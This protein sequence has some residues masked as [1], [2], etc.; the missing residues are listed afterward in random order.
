MAPDMRASSIAI[1]DSHYGFTL[2][3]TVN[4]GSNSY[5]WTLTGTGTLSADFSLKEYNIADWTT[6]VKGK[7]VNNITAYSV[8]EAGSA[9]QEK[10]TLQTDLGSNYTSTDLY[11]DI[12]VGTSKVPAPGSW[13]N[14]V[15]TGSTHPPFDGHGIL[16]LIT[17]SKTDDGDYLWV[18]ESGGQVVSELFNKK[19]AYL[20]G[21][22]YGSFTL[23]NSPHGLAVTPEPSSLVLLGSGLLILALMLSWKRRRNLNKKKTEIPARIAA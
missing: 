19:G 16:L 22:N 8:I 15:F 4:A 18:F 2:G 20:T 14:S 21:G 10:G 12:F 11:K 13:D 9:S 17:N 6:I 23:A 7:T 5:T 3:G 1:N